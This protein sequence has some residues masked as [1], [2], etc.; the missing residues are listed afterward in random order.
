M[1]IV[2]ADLLALKVQPCRLSICR[3]WQQ[4]FE[5][6]MT[7]AALQIPIALAPI[8]LLYGYV[9]PILDEYVGDAA[10]RDAQ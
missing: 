3:Y 1:R 7:S 9:A 8:W 6:S 5:A 10:T 2:T 4:S